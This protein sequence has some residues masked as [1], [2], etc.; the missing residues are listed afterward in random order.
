MT[1]QITLFSAAQTLLNNDLSSFNSRTFPALFG[2]HKFQPHNLL[3]RYGGI[4]ASQVDH[5]SQT[6]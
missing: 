5:L 1:Q 3:N 2:F 6:H 4:R